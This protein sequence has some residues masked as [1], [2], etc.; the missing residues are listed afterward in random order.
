VDEKAVLLET[1]SRTTRENAVET[2]RLA[3]DKGFQRVLLVTSALHM[4]RAAGAFRAVGLEVV[5]APTD[6]SVLGTGRLPNLLPD[7]GSLEATTATLHEWIGL[8][9]Y[10]ARG[11]LP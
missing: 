3:R 8:S 6:F 2:A 7:A 5:P 10:A 9:Y 11:W 1:R 4:R